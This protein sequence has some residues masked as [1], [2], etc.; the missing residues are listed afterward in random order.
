MKKLAVL[1]PTYNSAQ[2]LKESIDSILNQTYSNFDLYIYDDCSTD[3]SKEVIESY[4]DKRIFYRK[5]N[6]NLGI[7]K[8]LNKGLDELLPN[9]QYIARMDADDWAFPE[10]FEKQLCYLEEN[11]SI[12]LCGT[13]GFWLKN[14]NENV[15]SGWE[16][17]VENNYLKLYLLFSASFGHSSVFLRSNFFDSNALRYDEDI[18]TC[19]DWDFWIRVSENGGMHNLPDF[20]M[21]YRIVNNSNHRSVENKNKH[22]KERS[23]IIAN[24]WKTFEINLSPEQVFE[25][26]YGTN[27][28][29]NQNF[30]YKLETLIT[31]FNHLF[32]NYTKNLST[33]DKKKFGY[34]LSRRISDFWKR[35]NSSKYN[36]VIWFVILTKVKFIGNIQ[37][38]KNQLTL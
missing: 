28:T 26:Y 11:E 18:K 20:L 10:R 22:L 35:S 32:L 2:Y 34:L 37:L 13:Q 8:T 6:E 17:P 31:C 30:R 19:E 1:I 23:I 9:Y 7:S 24:Y 16:Y 3:N 29:I 25:Y 5:N 12:M 27:E 14:I 38:I 4:T 15:S 33:S 36:L 21:K